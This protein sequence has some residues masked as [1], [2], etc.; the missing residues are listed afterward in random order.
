MLCTSSEIRF[1]SRISRER[2]KLLYL[3]RK[4]PLCYICIQI[5]KYNWYNMN[6]LNGVDFLYPQTVAGNNLQ[7]KQRTGWK[8][9]Y[10]NDFSVCYF[11]FWKF[12]FQLLPTCY[13]EVQS[14]LITVVMNERSMKFVKYYVMLWHH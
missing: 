8:K 11:F 9:K 7:T 6:M 2:K 10:Q 14:R 4:F 5:V 1:F 3:L 12:Y 13:R